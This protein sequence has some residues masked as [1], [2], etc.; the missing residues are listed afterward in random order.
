MV[1]AKV[2]NC[3]WYIQWKAV[4]RLM[5]KTFQYILE[6]QSKDVKKRCLQKLGE[7]FEPKLWTEYFDSILKKFETKV[8]SLKQLQTKVVST[9]VMN[10]CYEQKMW[11]GVVKKM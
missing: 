7:S 1:G 10:E 5:N 11:T 2:V 9:K 4:T 6:D 8:L 3:K